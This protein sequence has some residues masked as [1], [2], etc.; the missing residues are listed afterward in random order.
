MSLKE[1]TP[2]AH[3]PGSTMNEQINPIPASQETPERKPL[4]ANE[5]PFPVFVPESD[6][7]KLLEVLKIQ[8]KE[9]KWAPLSSII[10]L[11][12]E[13]FMATNSNRNNISTA[14]RRMKKSLEPFGW[15]LDRKKYGRYLY[16]FMRT[17]E[18]EPLEPP[19]N[20]KE[21]HPRNKMYVL[22]PD[23]V[24]LQTNEI[25]AAILKKLIEAYKANRK[26]SHE[27]FMSAVQEIDPDII[28]LQDI[29]RKIASCR[30]ILKIKKIAWEILA[31]K[32]KDE[33]SR[34]FLYSKSNSRNN[35]T[36]GQKQP[37]SLQPDTQTHP[38]SEHA[39]NNAQNLPPKKTEQE[40]EAEKAEREKKELRQARER[41]KLA[42]TRE[43]I[44]NPDIEL[45][46]KE[47]IMQFLKKVSF[48]PNISLEQLIGKNSLDTESLK[49]FIEIALTQTVRRLSEIKD[50][51][52]L[53]PFEKFIAMK[54]KELENRGQSPKAILERVF[55]YPLPT[56]SP[57]P[58]S[59]TDKDHF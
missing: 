13:K 33:L 8:R 7:Q 54:L 55:A 20:F 18:E 1:R 41:A 29:E 42:I 37:I 40:T 50:T 28:T 24:I 43:I 45:Q 59:P 58:Q 46:T 34:Y 4:T 49:A 6:S 22:M 51:K 17:A 21:K 36:V 57:A 30:T 56:S 14:L 10:T 25:N 9:R 52:L 19:E 35:A 26:L 23:G 48:D 16:F 47:K 27:D 2:T 38:I 5:L 44:T 31:E 3:A 11:M 39:D 12:R 53:S 32:P 15:E